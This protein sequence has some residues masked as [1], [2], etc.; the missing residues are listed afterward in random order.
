MVEWLN[1]HTGERSHD[2]S[3]ERGAPGIHTIQQTH[4]RGKKHKYRYTDIREQN[5]ILTGKLNRLSYATAPYH[6][7]SRCIDDHRNINGDPMDH[8]PVMHRC[9][10]TRY[11]QKT[12]RQNAPLSVTNTGGFIPEN[13]LRQY[14]VE[15]MDGG[16]YIRK[17]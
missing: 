5:V 17:V 12:P 3:S 8:L 11:R 14:D 1:T 7:K 9:N 16:R 10:N 6:W 2:M 4:N 15:I 13:T